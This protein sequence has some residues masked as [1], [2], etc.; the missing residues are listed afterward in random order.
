[1]GKVIVKPRSSE[2]VNLLGSDVVASEVILD[3]SE[4]AVVIMHEYPASNAI[5]EGAL[6]QTVWFPLSPADPPIAIGNQGRVR[7]FNVEAFSYLRL[8]GVK[9][10]EAFYLQMRD[11][12]S[13]NS[14]VLFAATAEQA[15][16]VSVL[17]PGVLVVVP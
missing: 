10:S 11:K 13:S 15:R 14:P 6:V 8:K 5:I 4:I 7:V 1:M 3:V 17:N 16:S 9:A 2:T 12:E